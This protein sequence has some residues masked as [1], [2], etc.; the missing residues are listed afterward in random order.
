MGCRRPLLDGLDFSVLST[1]DATGLEK[2]FGE[3]EV[4][5]VVHGFV[6]DKAPGPDGFPMAFFQFSW[7]VV[8][9]DIL[10]VVNHFHEMGSFERSLNAT[11]L[12]LIPKKSDAIEVKDFRPISPVGGLYKILV[13][14]L[15]NRL[16]LVLPSIIST[17]HNAFVQ[18]RQ[19]LDSI[20]I[21]NEC[22][23]SRIRQG[24]PGVFC[25]ID[26]EKA[27]DHVNWDFLI[28]LLQRCGFPLHWRNWI[29][30]CISTVRFSILINGSPSGFFESSRG[31]RQGDPLLPLLFVVVME[32]L[33]RLMDRTVHGG[34]LSG[35]MVGNHEGSEVM[36]THLL[37]ADDTLMFCGADPSMLTQLGCVLT[38]FEA[39]SGLKMN[40]GK[41]KMVPVGA[42]PNLVDLADILGCHCASLPMKYL[43]LPL[44][45]KFKETTIWNPIIE[46]MECRLAG[47]KRLYLSKGGKI[48][49]IKSTLSSLPTYFLSLFPIS[50]GV[51]NQLEKLQ[52]D[53]LGVG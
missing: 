37:F 42:V 38:W 8:K 31:L 40:L 13:K 17:S 6:R 4:S 20:L 3:E 34:Y 41:S 10:R 18:G 51:A 48:T 29:R 25:K 26:V 19:I 12:A 50:A 11:F 22:L 23:D 49:L 53:F 33:S 9:T 1:K 30:F 14:L 21:A 43:G 35:F 46:K 44:R 32:A 5:S 28:Y 15:A 2:P 7:N 36:V 45:A 27:Y 39:F 52:R 16:R 47:W 24:E